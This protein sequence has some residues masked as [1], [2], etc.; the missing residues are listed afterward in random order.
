MK[1]RTFLTVALLLDAFFLSG[2]WT[3]VSGQAPN[4]VANKRMAGYH[5]SVVCTGEFQPSSAVLTYPVKQ[6]DYQNYNFLVKLMPCM[7]LN[8][9]L[10]YPSDFKDVKVDDFP[11]G[12]EASFTYEDTKIVTRI[13]PLLVGRG[14]KTWNGAALYEVSHFTCPRSACP[15]SEKAHH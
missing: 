8:G 12:V 13:T 2:P 11:G 3:S 4:P 15:C 14:S 1:E 10:I 9:K 7:S 6:A 5:F